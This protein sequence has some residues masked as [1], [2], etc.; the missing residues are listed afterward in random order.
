MP[1]ERQVRKVPEGRQGGRAFATDG[2]LPARDSPSGAVITVPP[3]ASGG[4]RAFR[5]QGRTPAECRSR[6]GAWMPREVLFPSEQFATAVGEDSHSGEGEAGGDGAGRLGE[7]RPGVLSPYGF[8]FRVLFV[9]FFLHADRLLPGD[10]RRPGGNPPPSGLRCCCHC[11]AGVASAG[12]YSRC[13][14]SPSGAVVFVPCGE[15]RLGAAFAEPSRLHGC[16]PR[17]RALFWAL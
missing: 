7:G 3:A 13:R 12:W 16:R 17:R 11:Q 8:R 15:R 5:E 6:V 4:L 1:G 2:G 14:Q 10:G 9:A